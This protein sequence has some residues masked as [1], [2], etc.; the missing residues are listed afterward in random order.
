MKII[1]ADC[2]TIFS[3]K[4]VN[5]T[6]LE[7]AIC[8]KN[9]ALTE[10]S[11]DFLKK[12]RSTYLQFEAE[13]NFTSFA[14]LN[15]QEECVGFCAFSVDT[16]LNSCELIADVQ[17]LFVR[18]DYRK[19]RT[20][21][22]ELIETAKAEAKAQGCKVM[23]WSAHSDSSLEKLFIKSLKFKPVYTTLCATL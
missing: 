1:K 10:I 7:Y 15:D 13:N 17:A 18:S 5:D 8:G 2:T 16:N 11:D 22:R 12:I 19:G 20:V 14:V 6:I 4:G 23:Y 21:G 9:P 3:M